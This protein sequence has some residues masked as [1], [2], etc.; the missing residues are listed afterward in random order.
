MHPRL[1]SRISRLTGSVAREILDRTADSSVISLAGG[2]PDPVLWKDWPLPPLDR[3]RFQYGSSEGERDLRAH[4]AETLEERGIATS[5][6][7]VLIT[8]GSQQGL[9]LVAK[10]LVESGTP[11]AVESPTYLAALQVFRLFGAHF[12]AITIDAEGVHPDALERCLQ[13][14]RPALVYLQPSFQNPSGACASEGRRAALAEVLDRF[15]TV[16]VEDDPYRALSYAGECPRPIVSRLR[17]ASWIYLST[18]SKTLVPGLRLGYLTCS[19]ELFHPLSQLKQAAD[20]H[21]NRVSQGLALSLLENRTEYGARV[22]FARRH[23]REK[24]N[25]MA[26][27]LQDEMRDL[28]TWDVPEGGMF[29]WLRLHHP[30]PLAAALEQAVAAGVA[31]MPG[32]PFFPE[33]S[34]AHFDRWIRLNFTHPLFSAIPVAVS[35]LAGVLRGCAECNLADLKAGR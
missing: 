18:T 27:S 3:N 23:Y 13:T 29:F 17:R 28:A 19:P 5:A 1:A 22:D 33:H 12:E 32:N 10:L 25:L 6:N 9:D 34:G 11:V 16:V 8:S 21:T 2:L 35:L 24:R 30:I 4:F 31:F 14:T 20:L 26:A 7:R 15:D